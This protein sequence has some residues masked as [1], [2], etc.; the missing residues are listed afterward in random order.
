MAGRGACCDC[1]GIGVTAGAPAMPG[2][3]ALPDRVHLLSITREKW[4]SDFREK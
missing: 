1:P 2:T 4:S 3:D